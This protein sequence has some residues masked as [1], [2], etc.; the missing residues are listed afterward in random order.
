MPSRHQRETIMSVFKSILSKIF[1]KA[2]AGQQP[3]VQA[4]GGAQSSVQGTPPI[5]G[6]QQMAQ[7]MSSP[8]AQEGQISGSTLQSVDVEAIL[9][10]MA[11]ENGQNLN[12]RQSIV[13]LLKLLDIDSSLENRK[14][15]ADELG[16][17]DDT[18]DSAKMNVWL[19]RKVMQKLAQNGGRV[20]RD[21]TD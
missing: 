21:L 5:T 3:Q 10:D 18:S 1:K 15:L 12:W 6:D 7:Q 16:Y 20:P 9:T 8:Q 14:A 19:H 17:A 11:A 13:D 2:S 4:G